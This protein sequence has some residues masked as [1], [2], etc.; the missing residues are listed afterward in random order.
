MSPDDGAMEARAE[1]GRVAIEKRWGPYRQAR[2]DAGLAPT[3]ALQS[4]RGSRFLEPD[5]EP[6]WLERLQSD[7]GPRLKGTESRTELRIKAKQ[8]AEAE[9]VAIADAVAPDGSAPPSVDDVDVLIAYWL[10]EGDRWRRRA[11]RDRAVADAHELK[12]GEADFELVRVMREA[13]R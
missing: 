6:F 10:E 8:F 7:N 13:G 12:A 3:K 4:G 11:A 9:R 5:E 2:L 1:R